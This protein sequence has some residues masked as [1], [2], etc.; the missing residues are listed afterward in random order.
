[1]AEEIKQQN[2]ST[3]N[4]EN[5][6]DSVIK[7]NEQNENQ[8]N[9]SQNDTDN[10]ATD[11]NVD[12]FTSSHN[13]EKIISELEA[14]LS[15]NRDLLLRKEAEID[16]LRKRF[17]KELDDNHKYGI[18]KFAKDM[19]N[20]LENLYRATD[21]IP[22]DFESDLTLKGFIDGVKMTKK[23][24]EEAL[25]THGIERMNPINSEF[26]H[27]FHQAVSQEEKDGVEPG[28]ILSVLDAGYTI[29]SRVLKP[30]MV[31]VSK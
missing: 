10:N 26:D 20:V 31:I 6:I 8:D 4:S 5:K 21:S 27:N 23:I 9:S 28:I 19:I 29:H 18:T 2:H 17:A 25:Q 15:E 16:N 11:N 3:L 1:M 14:N 30:A 7:Q 22:K 24:M 13:T 12:A